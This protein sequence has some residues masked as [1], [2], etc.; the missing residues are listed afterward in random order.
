MNIEPV[1][2]V[3]RRALTNLKQRRSPRD[4]NEGS[5]S[6]RKRINQANEISTLNP[7]STENEKRFG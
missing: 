4:S 3:K 7:I 6:A 2:N 5:E 1:I